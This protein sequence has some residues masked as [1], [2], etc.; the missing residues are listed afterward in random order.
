Q[1]QNEGFLIIEDFLTEKEVE[2]LKNAG[3]E[4]AK[5]IPKDIR[6]TVFTTT[7]TPQS[8]TSYF[9]ESGDKICYFFEPDALD[10]N[11][12]LKIPAELSLNK[13]GHALHWLHPTF[14]N[15]SFS[16][17]VKELCYK[18]RYKDPVILQSM[19]IYKNPGVGSEVISHQ[20]STFLHTDPETLIG[21]WFALDDATQENGCLWFIPGSHTSGIH[22]RYMRNQDPNSQ[23][24]LIYDRPPILY[25][26]S[27]FSPFPVTK[28]TCVVIHGRVVHKSEHNKSSKSRHAYTF[29]VMD[30]E[31][32]YSPENWLQSP[33]GFPLIYTNE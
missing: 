13:V 19:Y 26:T 22:R 25:P 6:K 20:D 32:K 10:E 30:V 28:G 12:E 11:G 24:L 2:E 7:S 17:K 21:F 31:S 14:K 15:I 27:S 33:Q 8:K 23:E 16:N 9:V 5:N 3:E 1:L 29:H 4:L 18:L